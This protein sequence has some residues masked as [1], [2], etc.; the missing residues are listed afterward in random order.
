MNKSHYIEKIAE[1]LNDKMTYTLVNKNPILTIER[2]L[3]SILKR[4]LQ[5]N[6]I[7][8]Q[9]YYLLH[10]SD[11]FIPKAY[12]LPKIHKENTLFRIIVSTALYLIATY[13]GKI[14]SNNIPHTNSYVK[15]SFKFYNLLSKKRH[16]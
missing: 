8:K 16:K 2:N 1:V 13:I 3:N 12:R 7:S 9:I 15:N 5:N 11:F 4:W 10:S 14:I 6:Y